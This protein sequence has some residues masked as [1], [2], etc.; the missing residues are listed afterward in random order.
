MWC[1]SLGRIPT[2]IFTS[3]FFNLFRDCF[4]YA[5]STHYIPTQILGSRSLLFSH[6]NTRF[7]LVYTTQPMANPKEAVP[8]YLP[9][10]KHDDLDSK[11]QHLGVFSFHDTALAIERRFIYINTTTIEPT[12]PRHK[13]PQIPVAMNT[14]A[15]VEH[16]LEFKLSTNSIY[17]GLR[18]QFSHLQTSQDTGFIEVQELTPRKTLRWARTTGKRFDVP[19]RVKMIHLLRLRFRIEL[20]KSCPKLLVYNVG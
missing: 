9:I 10:L 17:C 20:R 11:M 14:G 19:R 16:C 18:H 2:L 7:T 8:N 13:P 4:V 6:S 12:R 15:I 5:V 3:I 1:H